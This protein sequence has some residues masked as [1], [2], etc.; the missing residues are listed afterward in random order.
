MSPVTSIVLNAEDLLLEKVYMN[1]QT[2][3]FHFKNI[4]IIID[5][6]LEIEK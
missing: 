5:V 4:T 1:H 2:K 6:K 3:Y